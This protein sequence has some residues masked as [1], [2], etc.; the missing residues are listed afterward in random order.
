MT[1]RKPLR[2]AFVLAGTTLLASP[3]LAADQPQPTVKD[4]FDAAV[5]SVTG[6]PMADLD[7][8]MKHVL[9]AMKKLDPKPIPKLSP[10]EARKQPTPADAVREYLKEQGKTAAPL[11]GVATKDTAYETGG[12]TQPVRI[13]TPE[14]AQGPLP[15][16]VYYHGGG[17]VIADIDTYDATPRA[18]AKGANAVVVAVE[19]RHAPEAKFPAQQEDALAAYKWV[20]AN[21]KTFGGD[22]AKVA[23]LGESAGGNLVTNV[24]IAARDQG[25]E[26][27]DHVVA[28]YPMAGTN[29]D[30]P[31]YKANTSTKPLN[32]DMMAWF[33]DQTVR[34]D[35]D[36][37]DPRLDIV[38]KADLKG[39]PPFTVV[40]AQIDPLL[41]DGKALA[42]RIKAAGGQA[43]Y[44]EYPGVTH[45]FFGMGNVVS[46]A[47]Q[48]E[49]AVV[50]DLKK[51]FANEAT[52]TTA[53]RN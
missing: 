48:A 47:K 38:G 39:L 8:D 32:K 46:K 15:V 50:A 44:R 4:R 21:A 25:L 3:A 45:E 43:T 17:F 12:G 6:S 23:L 18:I 16:V 36:R 52:G 51:A 14:G 31:S 26:K 13:Y 30:T 49:D 22:P 37:A 34:T 11:P 28:V 10:E 27:P 35:A 42:D 20:L 40:T 24:A 1:V 41:D 29:L 5:S 2:L 9:D 7:I 33:Y 19:Y 53:P